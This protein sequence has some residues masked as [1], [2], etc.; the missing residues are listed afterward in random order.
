VQGQRQGG[1]MGGMG[2]GMG[3]GLFSSQKYSY[4]VKRVVGSKSR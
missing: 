3:M 4:D 1:W 2:L